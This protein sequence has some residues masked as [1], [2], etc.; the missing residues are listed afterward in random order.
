MDL[1]AGRGVLNSKGEM[2][3]C[4]RCVSPQEEALI[5]FFLCFG[6][7]AVRL[8][9]TKPLACDKVAEN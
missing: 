2:E 7:L 5:E 6:I 1:A 4:Q 3:S 9:L 8:R